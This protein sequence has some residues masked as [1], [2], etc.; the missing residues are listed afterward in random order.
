MKSGLVVLVGRSNVGKST[1]LN[2]LVGTKIA[3]T[4][5]RAQMTRHIIH[6]VMKTPDGEAVFV[7]TP[8]VFK[9]RRD[10]LSGKLTGKVQ[11][12]L[13]GID[14]IVYVVDPTRE[15]GDEERAVYGMIRHLDIPKILVINK[16]DLHK[17]ERKHQDAYENWGD[18]FEAVMSLSAL[19]NRHIQPLKEKVIEL[20]PEGHPLY[21]GEQLTNISDEFWVGEIIREKMY[22]VLDKE[23]PYSVTV[24]VDNM[25]DKK[26]IYVI[27]ARILTDAERYKKMIIGKGGIKI[28]EIGQMARK[29]LEQALNKK[30][31]LDLEVE[32]DEHWV[33]RV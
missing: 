13:H 26:D 28:K 19:K 4:S 2:T 10:R 6:G 1:L 24:E 30:V 7:D 20:L 25:E 12:S 31:F 22:S 33:E 32:V 23:I 3:A 14:L 5:F 18:D 27:E 16:S 8:G 15:I 21:E 11:E 9:H 17:S 29:E